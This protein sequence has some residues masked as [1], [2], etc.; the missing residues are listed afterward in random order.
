M[1][2]HL[3]IADSLSRLTKTGGAK[4]RNV[5]EDDANFVAETAVSRAMNSREIEVA[6]SCNEELI[7]VHQSIESGN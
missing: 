5:A 4:S 3:N 7:V 1:P 6:S 2:G